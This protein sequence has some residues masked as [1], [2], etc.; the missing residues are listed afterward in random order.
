MRKSV[1]ELKD[2]TPAGVLLNSRRLAITTDQLDLIYEYKFL[3]Y[4][5]LELPLASTRAA[6]LVMPPLKMYVLQRFAR[7]ARI[8]LRQLEEI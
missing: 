1:Q 2:A 7:H 3:V 8:K 6:W 4:N 5:E